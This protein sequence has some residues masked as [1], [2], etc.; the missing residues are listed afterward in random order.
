VGFGFRSP[1]MLTTQLTEELLSIA[2]FTDDLVG[3]IG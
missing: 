1:P 2:V 3:L